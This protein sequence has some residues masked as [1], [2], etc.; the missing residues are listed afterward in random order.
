LV[1][2]FNITFMRKNAFLII[3]AITNILNA[4]SSSR[5]ASEITINKEKLNGRAFQKLFILVSTLDIEVRNRLETDL[6]A[7]AM[8]KGY[9]SVKSL[10]LIPFSFETMKLPTK[11]EIEVKVKE[12][13]SDAILVVSMSRQEG[14]VTYTPGTNIKGSDQIVVGVLATILTRD[15][16]GST[17][18]YSKPIPGVSTQGHYEKGKTNFV[19]QGTLCDGVTEDVLCMLPGQNIDLSDLDKQSKI[20]AATLINELEKGKLLR[21]K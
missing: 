7:Y 10:D 20:Y 16:Q 4:C 8:E 12:S 9:A 17:D 14:S 15:K 5:Q 1:S 21:K 19:F 13:G 18:Q 2:L 6:C 3:L 11:E